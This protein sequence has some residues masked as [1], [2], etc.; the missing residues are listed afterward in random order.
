MA[1]LLLS[2][3][4]TTTFLPLRVI[5]APV[6]SQPLVRAMVNVPCCEVMSKRPKLGLPLPMELSITTSLRPVS[7]MRPPGSSVNNWLVPTVR[8]LTSPARTAAWVPALTKISRC[9]VKLPLMTKVCLACTTM[10]A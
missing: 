7:T 1:K 3:P 10:S 2:T 6:S 9:A 5:T 8:K 4:L